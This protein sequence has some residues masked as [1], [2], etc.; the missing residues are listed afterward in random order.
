MYFVVYFDSAVGELLIEPILAYTHTSVGPMMVSHLSFAD[1]RAP[2]HSWTYIQAQ[3]RHYQSINDIIRAL[4]RF[5]R[6]RSPRGEHPR[7]LHTSLRDY[8]QACQAP[9]VNGLLSTTVFDV[10]LGLIQGLQGN[11]VDETAEMDEPFEYDSDDTSDGGSDDDTLAQ[12]KVLKHESILFRIAVCQG[13][14]CLTCCTVAGTQ[15]RA[16]RGLHGSQT[17][18]ANGRS[19]PACRHPRAD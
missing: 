8:A 6:S 11:V 17:R 7:T 18:V 2:A 13:V 15:D 1:S 14:Q 9:Q 4:E 19:G 12:K 16:S 5:I 3:A 10:T